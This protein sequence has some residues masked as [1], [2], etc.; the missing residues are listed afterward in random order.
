[1]MN[2]EEIKTISTSLLLA[3]FLLGLLFSFD[4]AVA[5]AIGGILVIANFFLLNRGIE[6]LLLGKQKKIKNFLQYTLRFGLLVL[7]IY[8]V[9]YWKKINIPGFI[10]GLSVI[11]L[12]IV[13]DSIK[14]KLDTD[15]TLRSLK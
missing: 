6:A 15:R 3:L 12:G 5:I 8:L 14:N 1:M 4:F 13:I 2:I 9:F 10:V 7:I 11:F